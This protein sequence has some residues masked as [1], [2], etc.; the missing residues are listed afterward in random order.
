MIEYIIRFERDEGLFTVSKWA[1]GDITP[2]VEYKVNLAKKRATC[3]C[4]S[5]TYR[6]YCK[7][8]DMCREEIKSERLQRTKTA[9]RK[10]S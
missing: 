7:H 5:G 3:S 9:S 6:G 10:T 2:M 1:F 4:P 8:I